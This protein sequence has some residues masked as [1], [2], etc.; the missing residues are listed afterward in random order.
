MAPRTRAARCAL[1]L[2]LVVAPRVPL[3]AQDHAPPAPAAGGAGRSCQAPGAPVPPNDTLRTTLHLWLEDA[4]RLPVST[5]AFAEAALQELAHGFVRPA[6]LTIEPRFLHLYVSPGDAGPPPCPWLDA[7]LEVVVAREG[8]ASGVRLASR[9]DALEL[10]PA[11]LDAVSRAD[12]AGALGPLPDYVRPDSLVMRIRLGQRPPRGATALPLVAMAVPY[13]RLDQPASQIARAGRP[14]QYPDIARNQGIEEKLVIQFTV[15]AEGRAD[16]STVRFLRVTYR[17]FA[18]AVLRA[19]PTFRFKP[20]EV[21]GCPVPQVV[22][23]PFEFS[24]RR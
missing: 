10:N 11:L 2:C 20:A 23:L 18:E 17:D 22:Q 4:A 13:V 9:S 6:S 8:T 5:R 24:L 3:R 21:G 16:M 15:T 14:P 12:S 19:L 1:A 7:Q